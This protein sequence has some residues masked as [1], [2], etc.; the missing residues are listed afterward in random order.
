MVYPN[1]THCICEGPGTTRHLFEM[2]ESY[3]HERLP[4]AVSR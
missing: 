3:L 2:L 4:L 1:R